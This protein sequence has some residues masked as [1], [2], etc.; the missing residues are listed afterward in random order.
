MKIMEEWSFEQGY[1]V[2]TIYI[3]NFY[4]DIKLPSNEDLIKMG[5]GINIS[6]EH[7]TKDVV[8]AMHA[9]KKIVCVWIDRTVTKETPDVFKKLIDM[10]IDSFCTDYPLEVAKIRDEYLLQKKSLFSE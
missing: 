1:K 8:E 4:N 2:R 3:Q 10:K 7:V 9:A 6:F 5:D